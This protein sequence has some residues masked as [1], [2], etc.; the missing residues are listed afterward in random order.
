[1]M[2]TLADFEEGYYIYYETFDG[3]NGKGHVSFNDRGEQYIK[4]GDMCVFQGDIKSL[5]VLTVV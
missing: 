2:Q 3:E 4:D 5:K 1:M